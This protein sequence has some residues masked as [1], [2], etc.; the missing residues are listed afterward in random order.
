MNGGFQPIN[1]TS[2]ESVRKS[3][4]SSNKRGLRIVCKWCGKHIKEAKM[5]R[6]IEVCRKNQDKGAGKVDLARLKEIDFDFRLITYKKLWEFVDVDLLVSSPM[7]YNVCHS[8]CK[9]FIDNDDAIGIYKILSQFERHK[10]YRPLLYWF[11]DRVERDFSLINGLRLT[12]ERDGDYCQYIES[13]KFIDTYVE[14][15]TGTLAD[16]INRLG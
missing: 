1:K 11:C 7:F 6:H 15:Y 3:N 5:A 2:R 9:R 16:M 4:D 12:I 13:S 10:Y 14:V 8:Q